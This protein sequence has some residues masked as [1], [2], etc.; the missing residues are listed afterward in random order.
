MSE[1]KTPVVFRGLRRQN[2][3]GVVRFFQVTKLGFNKSKAIKIIQLTAQQF[4]SKAP[5]PAMIVISFTGKTRGLGV[6][7]VLLGGEGGV[8]GG[9]LFLG[10]V[11]LVVIFL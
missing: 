3:A 2:S 4:L 6:G 5:A 9:F 11:F 7:M 10:G 8:F 1:F